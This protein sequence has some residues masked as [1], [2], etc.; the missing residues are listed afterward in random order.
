MDVE[1]VFKDKMSDDFVKKCGRKS[2]AGWRSAVHTHELHVQMGWRATGGRGKDHFSRCEAR[3]WWRRSV[4]RFRAWPSE[5]FGKVGFEMV[6]RE[7][8]DSYHCK[9][10]HI[11]EDVLAG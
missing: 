10:G 2:K 6:I 7:D 5:E 4:S 1:A 11:G 9:V 3:R 8:G